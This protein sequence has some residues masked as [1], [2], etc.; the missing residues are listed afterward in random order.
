MSKSEFE[1]LNLS[2]FNTRGLADTTKRLTVFRWLKKYHDGIIFLQETHTSENM[3][4]IWKNNGKVKYICVMALLLEED[5]VFL[6]EINLLLEEE[7]DWK[8]RVISVN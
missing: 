6:Q 8:K 2:T 5:F 7:N 1:I 3:Y 4:K